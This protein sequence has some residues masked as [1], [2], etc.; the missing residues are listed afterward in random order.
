MMV[1]IFKLFIYTLFIC[2]QEIEFISCK[3]KVFIYNSKPVVFED[4]MRQKKYI[5][6]CVGYNPH[7]DPSVAM[8][9][10]IAAMR[11]GH[12]LVPNGVVLRHNNCSAIDPLSEDY[13]ESAGEPALR[14]CST[15]WQLQVSFSK[16]FLR[17]I[18]SV[19]QRI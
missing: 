8:E 3:F 1:R 2:K 19:I 7:M 10:S 15:Y 12:S 9:F 17:N 18:Y 14:I 4:C 11:L 6:L 5:L 16:G 13:G